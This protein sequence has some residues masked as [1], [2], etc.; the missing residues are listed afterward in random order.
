MKNST[1]QWLGAVP[2]E[3][4]LTVNQA[5]C[6]AKE[7]ASQHNAKTHE[8]ARQ[9]WERAVPRQL[10]LQ[11]V[12]NVCRECSALTPFVFNN[13]NTFAAISKTLVDDGLKRMPP[14]EAQ[15]IRTTVAHYVNGLVGKK[16]L[17]QVLGHFETAWQNADA[18]RGMTPVQN[19]GAER[20]MAG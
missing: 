13:G 17:L 16:E 5:L 9:I 19:A 18:A 6:Q 7:V 12:L 11:E 15:I 10:T 8:P 20:Q 2:W 3:T 4:V 14:V 1:K